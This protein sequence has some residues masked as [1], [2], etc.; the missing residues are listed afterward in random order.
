MPDEHAAAES[1]AGLIETETDGLF[2]DFRDGGLGDMLIDDIL[3]GDETTFQTELEPFARIARRGRIEAKRK[4]FR[5]NRQE[6]LSGTISEL[7]EQGGGNFR[8]LGCNKFDAWTWVPVTIDLMGGYCDELYINTWIIN[9]HHVKELVE[10][11]KAGNVGKTSMLIGLLFKT[12]EPSAYALL[13]EELSKRSGRYL[14]VLSHAKVTLIGNR[15]TGDFIVIETS[16]NMSTNVK[17]EQTAM[18]NDRELYDWYKVSIHAPVKARP[19]VA[20]LHAEGVVFQST[21]L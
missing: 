20:D 12:R 2:D 5:I 7:P 1:F 18:T 21:R 10:L 16:A 15:K 11:I 9:H 4:Y 14:A 13:V 3:S 17:V 6:N 19:C 8:V